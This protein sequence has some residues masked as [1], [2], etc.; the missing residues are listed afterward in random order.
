VLA[1][2]T[3]TDKVHL[4][5]KLAPTGNKSITAISKLQRK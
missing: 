3:T 5:I 2:L 4:I 1:Y